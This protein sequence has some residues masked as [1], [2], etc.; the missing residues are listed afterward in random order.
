MCKWRAEDF[1]EIMQGDV[2]IGRI[3]TPENRDFVVEAVNNHGD[4]E[5]RVERLDKALETAAQDY[6]KAT[7]KIAELE[8]DFD[9]INK[10]YGHATAIIMQERKLYSDEDMDAVIKE[11]EQ[12]SKT[13][14]EFFD[15]LAYAQR[16][17]DS[18][19]RKGGN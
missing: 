3:N 12:E 16:C 6:L 17:L 4:L 18:H 7:T 14:D 2:P 11:V 1:G 5:A 9:I 8:K 19:Q 15:W 10:H 13:T